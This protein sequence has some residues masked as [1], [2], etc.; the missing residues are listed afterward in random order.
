MAQQ[1]TAWFYRSSAGA[2]IDLLL[3]TAAG[4]CHAVEVKRSVSNPR[5]SKRF[6]LACD[7]LKVEGRSVIHPGRE[8]YRLDARTEAIPF[9]EVARPDSRWPAQ[10]R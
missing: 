9:T 3:E 4:H 6:Q 8:R 2:E 5:P 1:T 10:S 7:D